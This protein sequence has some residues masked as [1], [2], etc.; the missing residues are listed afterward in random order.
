MVET[1]KEDICEVVAQGFF[2]KNFLDKLEQLI[3]QLFV[4]IIAL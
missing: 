2:G 1:F 4:H 3:V